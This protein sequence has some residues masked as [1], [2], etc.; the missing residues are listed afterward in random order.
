MD[1]CFE[2]YRLARWEPLD[3]RRVSWQEDT[4]RIEAELDD[5]TPGQLVLRLRLAQETKEERYRVATTPFV[6]PDAR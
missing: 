3:D 1:S 5:S 2:T 6:C 4:A